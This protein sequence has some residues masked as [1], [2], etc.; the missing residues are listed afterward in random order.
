M[1]DIDKRLSSIEEL[2]KSMEE[3]I[4]S[5]ESRLSAGEKPKPKG[6]TGVFRKIPCIV[7]SYSVSRINGTDVY[8][9]YIYKETKNVT[10]SDG[11][12]GYL[13]S[14]S[15]NECNH[16]VGQTRKVADMFGYQY[17]KKTK[18]EALG[19]ELV[20]KYGDGLWAFIGN[21][22]VDA[23]GV[24]YNFL[25]GEYLYDSHFLDFALGKP[26]TLAGCVTL[27]LEDYYQ[28]E[29][30]EFDK[31]W[32]REQIAEKLYEFYNSLVRK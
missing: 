27:S 24:T 14:I 5:L 1:K 9:P 2:L 17:D 31:T 10:L 15:T 20:S 30:M 29:P 16:T 32:T 13:R 28:N 11:R 26:V 12:K 3:R 23:N 22:A 19:F 6:L 25:Y 4:A 18:R 7:L 21:N 8:R